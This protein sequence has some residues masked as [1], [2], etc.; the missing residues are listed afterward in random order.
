VSAQVHTGSCEGP[1]RGAG[2][3]QSG[4]HLVPRLAILGDEDVCE[5]TI[6]EAT[7]AMT[8]TEKIPIHSLVPGVTNIV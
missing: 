1:S 4:P 6:I 8:R 7:V 2:L 3:Q 5:G